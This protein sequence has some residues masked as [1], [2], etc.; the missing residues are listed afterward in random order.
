MKLLILTASFL[1][2]TFS[3]LQVKA[4]DTAIYPK[5]GTSFGEKLTIT[6]HFPE[7][8]HHFTNPIEILSINRKALSSPI[9]ITVKDC[10]HKESDGAYYNNYKYNKFSIKKGFTYT[11]TG[12]EAGEFVC[13]PD[14]LPSGHEQGFYFHHYFVPI[15]IEQRAEQDAAA[16]P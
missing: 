7:N 9:I 4:G 6:G 1:V 3:L 11:L 12:Y 10:V 8:F 14:W 2:A 5:L 13:V 15:K 16:N